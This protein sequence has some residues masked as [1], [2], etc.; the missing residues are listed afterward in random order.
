MES[1]YLQK[2]LKYKKKLEL[3][4]KGS[5]RRPH[6]MP[7]ADEYLI[8]IPINLVNTEQKIKWDEIINVLI[9]SFRGSNKSIIITEFISEI[10]SK[11]QDPH[12]SL[13]E[14][15]NVESAIKRIVKEAREIYEEKPLI[16]KIY[17]GSTENT[18]RKLGLEPTLVP[19]FIIVKVYL[20]NNVELKITIYNYSSEF[21]AKRSVDTMMTTSR[22]LV[23]PLRKGGLGIDSQKNLVHKE[24]GLY[25]K[26]LWLLPLGAPELYLRVCINDSG[27]LHR[28]DEFNFPC[29]IFKKISGDFVV[30]EISSLELKPKSFYLF[31][32]QNTVI[33]GITKIIDRHIKPDFIVSSLTVPVDKVIQI[34]ILGKSISR[35]RDTEIII[36]FYNWTECPSSLEELKQ[37]IDTEILGTREI[38]AGELSLVPP[39]TTGFVVDQ[40]H[41]LEGLGTLTTGGARR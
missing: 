24:Q 20:T 31:E 30:L 36:N 40:R 6:F 22:E 18:A 14:R 17:V 4:Q 9:L 27:D 35:N 33:T 2:Y 41:G 12:Y 19:I 10:A 16:N 7:Q 34:Q 32:N 5:S 3:L 8:N 15:T 25:E 37:L 29:E 38:Q 26:P 21:D 1:V 11:E 13:V 23:K 28:L 39:S